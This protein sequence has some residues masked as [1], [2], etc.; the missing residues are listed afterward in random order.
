M[1]REDYSKILDEIFNR[2]EISTECME[3][4]ATS[5]SAYAINMDIKDNFYY[6]LMSFLYV[7]LFN[8]HEVKLK[9]V[10]P[11]KIDKLKHG[12][13]FIIKL[14]VNNTDICI[15]FFSTDRLAPVDIGGSMFV[16]MEEYHFQGED[17]CFACIH[18]TNQGCEYCAIK[19][20]IQMLPEEYSIKNAVNTFKDIIG[21]DLYNKIKKFIEYNQNYSINNNV[22]PVVVNET[23]N[24]EAF[25]PDNVT[26]DF[27]KKLSKLNTCVIDRIKD[28]ITNIR[29]LYD[30][31]PDHHAFKEFNNGNG[32]VIPTLGHITNH[33]SSLAEI[34]RKI[35]HGDGLR[36]QEAFEVAVM[37]SLT[38]LENLFEGD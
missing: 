1:A 2:E 26:T 30:E 8:E 28:M 22:E 38:K 7:K 13:V 17:G 18:N 24:T 4:F 34:I 20:V 32:A 10:K 31:S 6:S 3:T 16:V 9:S 19:K 33:L 23:K 5:N 27:V 15:P 14:G 25:D 21:D 36:F 35:Q 12:G 29:L 37:G 11:I